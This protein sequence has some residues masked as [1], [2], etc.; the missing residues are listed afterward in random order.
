MSEGCRDKPVNLFNAVIADLKKTLK[1][2]IRMAT[3]TAVKLVRGNV[4]KA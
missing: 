4:S 2:V 1:V 3:S